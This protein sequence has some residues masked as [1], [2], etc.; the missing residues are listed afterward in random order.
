MHELLPQHITQSIQTVWFELNSAQL[1]FIRTIDSTIIDRFK[2]KIKV[3][4]LFIMMK[5]AI[6][7]AIHFIEPANVETFTKNY[8][9]MVRSV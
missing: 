7:V 3:Q 9:E 5:I 4:T 2:K 1:I 8:I 6:N